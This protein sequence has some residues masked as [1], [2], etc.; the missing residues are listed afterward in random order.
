ML[1]LDATFLI[2]YLLSIPDP[3]NSIPAIFL[4]VGEWLESI[5]E[6]G[7]LLDE[8]DDVDLDLLVLARVGDLEV[9][10]LVVAS[11]VDVVLQDEVVGIDRVALVVV[12]VDVEQVAALEVGVEDERAV[13][14][15]LLGGR[16]ALDLGE[17]VGLG[18]GLQVD[19]CDVHEQISKVV[20]LH[21]G[22]EPGVVD[23]L[24]AEGFPKGVIGVL[25]LPAQQLPH[26][27]LHPPILKNCVLDGDESVADDLGGLVNLGHDALVGPRQL[28]L[29][30]AAGRVDLIGFILAVEDFAGSRDVPENANLDSIVLGEFDEGLVR[31]GIVELL[32]FVHQRL[33]FNNIYYFISGMRGY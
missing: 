13:V 24:F 15:A 20:L 9:E 16:L 14:F 4:R 10:P 29:V 32:S 28:F 30:E 7:L 8:V 12:F 18:F 1:S 23:L 21:P 17:V 27:V 19:A 33:Y 22:F 25:L 26:L 3:S 2:A 5:A 31:V 11:R 6:Q